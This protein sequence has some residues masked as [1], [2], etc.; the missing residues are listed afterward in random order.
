[1]LGF[2]W[3]SAALQ[4]VAVYLHVAFTNGRNHPIFTCGDRLLG[5]NEM[6]D[7]PRPRPFVDTFLEPAGQPHVF[8]MFPVLHAIAPAR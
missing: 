6:H 3:S 7:H 8:A 2:A 1:M 5:V 4:G